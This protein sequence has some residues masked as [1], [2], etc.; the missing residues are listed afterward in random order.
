MDITW[1][2][3]AC[4]RTGHSGAAKGTEG[5]EIMEQQF[6]DIFSLQEGAQSRFFFK[7]RYTC[8]CV[9]VFAF[10]HLEVGTSV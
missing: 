9:F 4:K 1:L 5:E 6:R 2:H 7:A 8:V 10:L 3:I